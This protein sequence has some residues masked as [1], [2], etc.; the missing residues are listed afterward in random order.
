MVLQQKSPGNARIKRNSWRR[1][2][3]SYSYRGELRHGISLRKK[4]LNR[5][6][7]HS[8]QALKG[9]DYKKLVK[10]NMMVDFS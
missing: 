5:K 7:R 10:T 4:Q 2:N 3:G 1:G 8:K 9:T 6:V